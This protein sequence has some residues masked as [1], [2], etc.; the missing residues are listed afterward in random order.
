MELNWLALLPPLIAIVLAI[1]SREVLLSLLVAVFVGATLLIGNPIGGF[2]SLLNTHMVGALTDSWNVSILIFCLSIGGLIGIIDKNGG[3]S[4]LANLLVRR[5]VS[6]KSALLTTW[7]L[8]LAIFFDDYANS[9]IVGNSMRPLTDRLGISREKLAFIV[10]S[11]AAPISSMALISTWVGM[12]LGL[13]REGIE[14][15][16]LNMGAYDVFLSS[17][18]FR[19]Y[20]ILALVF[21]LIIILT[22]RDY[23]PMRRAEERAINDLKDLDQALCPMSTRWYNALVPFLV[24]LGVTVVG[25]Y[26]NGGGFD[27]LSI[28]EAFSNA[29]ASVVLLWSSFAGISVAWLMSLLTGALKIH[30][31][32]DAFVEGVKSMV[33]PAMILT[34]AWTLSSIN[35]DLGTASLMVRIIGDNLPSFLLP[36]IMFLVPALVAFSTGTSWGTNAIVMPIAIELAYLTGGTSLIVPTIGAVLTGAVMGDHLSPVSDTT[37]MSSMAS[38][39]DHISHVKTQLP[40]AL[41]VAGVAILGGFIP[42]GLGIHPLF[43]LV[44]ASGLLYLLVRLLGVNVRDRSQDHESTRSNLTSLKE[45]S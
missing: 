28:Q 32:S 39:C 23:G 15:L 27:G 36:T 18:P 14:K 2:S 12:E 33:V 9:L 17:I 16:G 34:L 24:V 22:G 30:E 1:I 44:T 31:I 6:V 4:G 10:D 11:T 35:S 42:A 43:S 38:G 29:D 8:G 5:A 26:Y 25:L 19:F 3:T 37:I 40:Y 7:L 41:T 13:I 21:V 45:T 20:S